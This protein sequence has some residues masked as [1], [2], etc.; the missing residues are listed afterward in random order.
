[1]KSF[2]ENLHYSLCG[3]SNRQTLDNFR[4]LAGRIPEAKEAFLVASTLLVPGYIDAA[5]VEAIAGFI[6]ELDPDI[7]YSL[8]GFHP[9]YVM[10]DLPVTAL[11]DAN[12]AM[13]A[14]KRAGLREVHLGNVHLLR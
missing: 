6:A 14:A 5:E 13:A 12:A 11:K 4:R 7:P 3:V 1:M 10:T 9:D 2:D 8:L